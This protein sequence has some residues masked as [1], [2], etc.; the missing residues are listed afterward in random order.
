MLVVYEASR[1]QTGSSWP[2]RPWSRQEARTDN[3][4]VWKHAQKKERES[5]PAVMARI[6]K[7]L[8]QPC[9]TKSVRKNATEEG[10]KLARPQSRA[11]LGVVRFPSAT[12]QG[13]FSHFGNSEAGVHTAPSIN[14]R[15]NYSC[16]TTLRRE[17]ST[18]I[19]P[20][21]RMKPSFR[22][23]FMKKLTR[24]RVVPIISA[25]ISCDTF[26]TTFCGSPDT[27]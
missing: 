11:M 25:S 26:T 9:I 1:T 8:P 4:R 17:L 7:E 12:K 16:R 20:L 6:R 22:N 2:P 3:Q 27:P 5:D 21:Y 18:W 19:S 15:C 10:G 23:L 24:G 14:F 13:Q